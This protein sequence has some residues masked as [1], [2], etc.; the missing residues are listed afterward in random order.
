[1]LLTVV[2]V[3]FMFVSGSMHLPSVRQPGHHIMAW[4]M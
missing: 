1:M 2:Q 3:D 4:V